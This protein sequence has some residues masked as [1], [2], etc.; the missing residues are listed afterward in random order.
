MDIV[1]YRRRLYFHLMHVL[2]F[3]SYND[4]IVTMTVQIEIFRGKI[5]RVIMWLEK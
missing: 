3:R 1:L 5:V 4:G 2:H